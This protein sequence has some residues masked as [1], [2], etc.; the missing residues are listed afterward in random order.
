MIKIGSGEYCDS[1]CIEIEKIPDVSILLD[2]NNTNSDVSFY[3]EKNKSGFNT[4]ITEF[5]QIV[6][7][8]FSNDF[9]NNSSIDLVWYAEPV[10]NQTFK[11]NI[12]FYVIL[13]S[14]DFNP[15]ELKFRL[16]SLS[17]IVKASLQSL[18]YT[19]S[20]L[21]KAPPFREKLDSLKKVAIFKEDK[22][23]STQSYMMPECYTY[24]K[25]PTTSR[26]FATLTDYLSNT[27]EALIS[28]SL[29]PTY[30]AYNEKAYIENTA[31][32]LDTVNKGIHDMMI[33]NVT[34]VVAERLKE[35]YTYYETNK[36]NALFC[37]NVLL[38]AK[39]LDINV[40]KAK[41]CGFIDG[42]GFGQDKISLN[43]VDIYNAGVSFNA[44][45]DSL[46]WFIN[47]VSMDAL[48][49]NFPIYYDLGFDFRR[50]V[51]VIT[52]EEGAEIFCLP[53]GCHGV[54]SGLK[55]DYT[56]KEAKEFSKQIINTGDIPVGRLKSSFSNSDIYFNRKDINKHMLIVGVPGMG[57][58]TYSVGLLHTL[59]EK[60]KIPFLVIEPAKT[61]Y[62]AMLEVIPDLQIFTFGKN[63][64]SPM[65]INPFVPP[66]G[67]KIKQYKSI[68]KTAFA[69]GVSM[70]ESLS[71]LF[72][73][74]INE[75]YNDFGWYDGDTLD[76]GGEIFNI[77]DFALCFKKVFE[78]HG[79]V[80]EAKNVGTAGLLRLVS[81]SNL[82]DNYHSVSVEDMLTKPTIIEL[83]AVQNKE[84]KSLIMALLLLNISAFIDNNYLGDGR[85]RNIVLIEEA[86]NL[87]ST[88]DSK[89]EG[90]ASPNAVAQELVKNMLAEKR[91]QGLGIV[92]ADQ[93]PEKVTSD[94]I[95]L[96][97]VKL[98]FNL[99]ERNDKE[100]F[101]NSTNMQDY[102]VERMT[103]LVEGEA[104]F[105]MGGMSSPEELLIPDYR[106]NHNIAVTITDADVKQ[107]STYWMDRTELLKPYPDCKRNCFCGKACRLR[108]KE[109]AG[110]VAR[111]IFNK[112]FTEKS[113]DV[114]LLTNVLLSLVK[115]S[116]DELKGRVE[117]TKQLFYCIKIQLLR[118]VKYQTK[119]TIPKELIE[120][121]F[122]K[123]KK[124]Q[125][126]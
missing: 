126:G 118:E 102:Q 14:L 10:L 44:V 55:I 13:R 7:S 94:V 59:W 15:Q 116:Q 114:K 5:Y 40:L 92:I 90:S 91:A 41:V 86:H 71:K 120:E 73:E 81:L 2:K 97:N 119:I 47:D 109:I 67:V 104:F 113:D 106:A 45:F 37:Y 26:N 124:Q 98:G 57:K 125:G 95:K 39:P 21:E 28:I 27:P 25:I 36:D 66:K 33:G 122:K 49:S 16:S 9:L 54:T 85:L 103:Q 22:I 99:V 43:C 1:V 46:P 53:I 89:E 30:F 105:Y 48:Y 84:E 83:A 75:I 61:E 20:I 121:T 93:S 51:N 77:R 38:A 24:D 70:V 80:G 96:T 63:D 18:K 117:L 68:L 69:A 107:R 19:S 56:I 60:F 115:E 62:R 11:A 79:Y 52:A 74:T 17:S 87:L 42:G 78:R 101:A 50:L 108:E 4:L 82:F 111:R 58:T 8:N 110:T 35:K 100:I 3:L 32:T 6:K 31:N 123:A 112:Y 76:S 88:S 64:V 65:P 34:N 12:K 23:G 72:E 29:I